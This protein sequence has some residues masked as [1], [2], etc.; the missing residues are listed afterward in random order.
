PPPGGGG[1]GRGRG[2]SA[3]FFVSDGMR[4]DLVERFAAEGAMPAMAALLRDGVRGANGVLPPMPTNTGAGWATLLTGAWSGKTGSINN[5]FHMPGEPINVGRRGFGADLLE[6]ETIVQVAER[7]GLRTLSFEWASTIPSRVSGPVLSYRTFLGARGTA[8][9]FVADGLEGGPLPGH[10]LFASVV[11][12]RPASEWPSGPASALPPMASNFM[13]PTQ[14][15][16]QNPNRRLHLLVTASTAAGYDRLTVAE[17]PDAAVSLVTLRA[18]EWAPGVMTLPDGRKA[19]LWMKCMD[20]EPD[21]SRV[22]LYCTALSRPLAGPAELEDRVAG[23]DLPPPVTAD[24]GPLQAGIVDEETYVEQALLWFDYA[25][26]VLARL[27]AETEP[28]LLLVGAP[29]TDEFCHQFLARI[30]P[31]YPGYDPARAAHYEALIRLAYQRTD[32][33]FAHARALMPADTV[34]VISSDHGFAPAWKSVNLNR[35]LQENGWQERDGSQRPLAT[36]QAVAYGVGGTANIYLNLKGRDPEGVV[37]PHE[38]PTLVQGID[39]AIGSLRDPDQPDA[40]VVRRVLHGSAIGAVETGE[41]PANM[42]HPTRTGDIVVFA[43]PPYQF[44]GADPESVIG[45]A[46][47]LGQHGYLPDEDDPERAITMRST[48]IMHGPGI[49]PG[50]CLHGGRAI[51]LAP[52]LACAIGIDGPQEADGRVLGEVFAE[53]F[54]KPLP[55][56][57]PPLTRGEGRTE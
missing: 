7:Q 29:V 3:L 9:N 10:H 15:A 13:L 11:S 2:P 51:D 44:D 12:F 50:Y 28:D 21:L 54:E 5:T 34:T 40:A 8:A 32:A 47:L 25:V 27:V 4:Q 17:A 45:D 36:S 39:A 52:T 24:Y 16:G 46:P 33:F 49:R 57:L 20:L 43:A 35:L 30:S 22:R 48:F 56:P 18:G 23:W 26:P 19:S 14:D 41:G 38:M 1:W 31:D 55:R 6:V 42:L 37:E 53:S